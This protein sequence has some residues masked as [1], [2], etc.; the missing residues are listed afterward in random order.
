MANKG[1]ISRG[2]ITRFS[3]A[4]TAIIIMAVG[5]WLLISLVVAAKGLYVVPHVVPAAARRTRSGVP[6]AENKQDAHAIRQ[7]AAL[8][9]GGVATSAAWSASV[10]FALCTYKPWRIVHNSIGV[11]Q[12][13]T[14]LPLILSCTSALHEAAVAHE[15]GINTPACRK[16][17]LAL[18]AS[19]IWAAVAVVWAPALTS[20]NVRTIDPVIFPRGGMIAAAGVHLVTAF[21]L[22]WSVWHGARRASV[23]SCIS[24]LCALLWRLGPRT[25]E[26]DGTFNRAAEY[27]TAS[28]AFVGF[29]A[30]AACAPFPLA[31]VPSLLGKRAARSYGAWTLLAA[32]M[33]QVLKDAEE[34]AEADGGGLAPGGLRS[35]RRGLLAM[36][37]VHLALLV[38]ARPLLETVVVYPAA[39]AC[40]P[41]VAGSLV[42]YLLTACATFG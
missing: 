36:S 39:M 4:P 23:R 3:D 33:L 42:V 6:I 11:A 8:I 14:A 26:G 22:A 29:S 2:E 24:G 13:L 18:V 5:S 21:H 17:A 40:R 19:N 15:E 38:I 41:A 37:V 1:L 34:D 32:V 31:T 10:S 35:L 25:S 30:V 27:A 20:A 9:A 28:M 16:L 7:P 12:G